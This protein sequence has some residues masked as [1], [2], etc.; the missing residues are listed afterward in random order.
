MKKQNDDAAFKEFSGVASQY[1]ED[2]K[3]FLDA[4]EKYQKAT[5]KTYEQ[6]RKEVKLTDEE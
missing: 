6:Y 1:S 2:S 5:S 3:E 4:Q